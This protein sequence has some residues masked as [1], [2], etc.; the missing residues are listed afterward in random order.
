M[1]KVEGIGQNSYQDFL[2]IMRENERLNSQLKK[3]DEEIESLKIRLTM[4][5]TKKEEY[6]RVIYQRSG[7]L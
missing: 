2:A 1:E 4:E 5:E 6:L 3:K 7:M